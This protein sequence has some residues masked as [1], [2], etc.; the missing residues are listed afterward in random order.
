MK[1]FLFDVFGST[2]PLLLLRLQDLPIAH[3]EYLDDTLG[4]NDGKPVR[5]QPAYKLF[6]S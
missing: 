2:R 1:P 5:N 3:W 6:Q 4:N